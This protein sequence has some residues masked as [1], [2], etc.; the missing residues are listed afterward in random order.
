MDA[1]FSP[2][3]ISTFPDSLKRSVFSGNGSYYDL[4]KAIKS[5]RMIAAADEIIFFDLLEKLKKSEPELHKLFSSLESA[6]KLQTKHVKYE[7]P[8]Y[9]QHIKIRKGILKKIS[10]G[11]LQP[12]DT[13]FHDSVGDSQKKIDIIKSGGKPL[14]DDEDLALGKIEYY[15][16]EKSIPLNR[17]DEFNWPRFLADYVYPFSYIR[18]LDPYLYIS[19]KDINLNSML[20]ALIRQSNPKSMSI[21]IISDL[22]ADNKWRKDEVIEKLR[23]ELNL[24]KQF[25]KSLYLY[26]QKGS[27]NN[28][29]HKR[30]IWT[31]FWTLLSERGFDFLKLKTG[32]GTVTRE[33]TLFLTGKYSSNNSLWHQIGQN[34]DHYLSKSEQ[35]TL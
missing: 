7:I 1:F 30:A 13:V 31:N 16:Q 5:G 20:K 19:V 24:P 33:N 9:L 27:A 6:G 15:F 23:E 25:R 4:F 12:S 32:K 28:V 22:E 8:E 17:G 18:I 29:F 11:Y 3:F 2:T 26:H 35:F 21:E 10:S 14:I 34:W